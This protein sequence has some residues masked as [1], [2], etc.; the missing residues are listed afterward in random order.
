MLLCRNE[1]YEYC[2]VIKRRIPLRA[3]HEIPLHTSAHM[4][5][6]KLFVPVSPLKTLLIELALTIRR[7]LEKI[8]V[9]E[10]GPL[11]HGHP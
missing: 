7:R 11:R 2:M 5:V 6:C 10:F 9:E 4:G 1:I 3:T 8:I